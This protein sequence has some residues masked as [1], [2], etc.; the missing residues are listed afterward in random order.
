MDRHSVMLADVPRPGAGA[1]EA[2]RPH[3]ARSPCHVRTLQYEYWYAAR[4]SMEQGDQKE[5]TMTPD[6]GMTPEPGMALPPPGMSPPDVRPFRFTAS[7][8]ALAA[9]R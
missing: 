5:V 7:D 8:D 9:L 3:A 2:H 6:P 1:D 4:A